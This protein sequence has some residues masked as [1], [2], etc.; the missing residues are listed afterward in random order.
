M[1]KTGAINGS[2]NID[3]IFREL[4]QF[5]ELT[6]AAKQPTSIITNNITVARTEPKSI[7]AL[8]SRFHSSNV[9]MLLLLF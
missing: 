6:Y 2:K 9:F 7:S 3:L 1:V 4:I 8:L 5:S